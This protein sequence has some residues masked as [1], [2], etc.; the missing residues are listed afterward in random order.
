MLLGILNSQA[1]G[2][3]A[4]AFDLLESTTLTSTASSVTFSGLGA[5][6][7]YKHLQIRAVVR[8][9]TNAEMQIQYNDV[10]GGG[11]VAHQLYGDGSSVTSAAQTGRGEGVIGKIGTTANVFSAF[12]TDILDFASANKKTTSR[13]L[14]S[15]E[16]SKVLLDSSLYY[17]TNNAVTKIKVFC[18]IGTMQIGSRLSLYGVK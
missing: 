7:D 11:Y 4:G 5:Y 6:S 15:E 18:G 1:A 3:A 14:A 9:S 12:V 16:T 8:G 17:G 10:A 13:S 2:G